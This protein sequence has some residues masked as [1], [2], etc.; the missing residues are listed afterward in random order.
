MRLLL[1]D[2][3]AQTRRTT[4]T[5]LKSGAQ[6][7]GTIGGPA[8]D[9]LSRCLADYGAQIAEHRS[10]VIVA[11]GTS[12]V[13]DAPN[14][15]RVAAIVH[16]HL[17]APLRVLGGD[18][19]AALAFAGARQALSGQPGHVVLDIGGGSTEI[20][21]GS[22]PRP[23][24]S[25]SLALGCVRQTERFLT[26]DP[27]SPGE[28]SA[29]E[30]DVG[31]LVRRGVESIGGLSALSG[32][33][34]IGVAGT[35]TS[36]AA[37]ARGGY[38]R[39]AIHGSTLR[40]EDIAGAK[41]RLAA[42]SGDERRR[43]PGLHPDRAPVIVAGAVIAQASLQALDREALI[44]SELDILDGLLAMARSEATEASGKPNRMDA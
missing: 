44:V 19:E 33:G 11:A 25:V 35:I 38:D 40:L 30:I 41:G 8:F 10:D 5:G 18:D 6:P 12:A 27:P 36:L 20:V 24:A 26:T 7:D 37:I 21:W 39:D 13:R 23:N 4:V 17:A 3:V 22:G 2:D 34:L 43:V 16:Q 31:R 42:M 28:V 29:M 9:R 15:A 32:M 14:H 1:A